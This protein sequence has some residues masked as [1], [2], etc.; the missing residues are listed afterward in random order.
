MSVVNGIGSVTGSDFFVV[1]SSG[2]GGKDSFAGLGSL[3]RD[4][5]NDSSD[6]DRASTGG[7]LS[8]GSV[9]STGSSTDD[10]GDVFADS[11]LAVGGNGPSDSSTSLS[12][13]RMH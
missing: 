4:V 1:S 8:M 11:S 6:G 12:S 13:S 5:S 2:A 10:D 3:G 9:V 7:G